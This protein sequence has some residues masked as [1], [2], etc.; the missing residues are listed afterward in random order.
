MAGIAWAGLIAGI[1][2]AGLIAG[3]ACKGPA[4]SIA[5]ST[6]APGV[7][8]VRPEE[9]VKG[10][11]DR[12]DSVFTEAGRAEIAAATGSSLEADDLGAVPKSRGLW[13]IA[14]TGGR[15]REAEA[16]CGG[17]PSGTGL[18]AMI[19]RFDETDET[20]ETDFCAE[21]CDRTLIDCMSLSSSSS[22]S[23]SSSSYS[24]SSF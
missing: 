17:L 6:T 24:S 23:T 7:V 22:S 9:L 11:F 3:F 20:D 4:G 12:L 5:G 13:E 10:V 21:A 15:S 18:V 2:W 1:A 19:G 14:G 16:I 8:W